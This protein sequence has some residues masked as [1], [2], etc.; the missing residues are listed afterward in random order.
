MLEHNLPRDRPLPL[1]KL[2]LIINWYLLLLRPLFFLLLLRI[3]DSLDYELSMF[4]IGF[5]FFHVFFY[6]EEFLHLLTVDWVSSLI[7]DY[8]VF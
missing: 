7:L 8:K 3:N 6:A 2:K 1:R 4:V 5:L